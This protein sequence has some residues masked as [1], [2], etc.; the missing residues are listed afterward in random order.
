VRVLLLRLRR[1]IRW[2]FSQQ[3]RSAADRGEDVDAASMPARRP[4][5]LKAAWVPPSLREVDGATR[6]QHQ[7]RPGECATGGTRTSG[8]ALAWSRLMLMTGRT[9]DL[10]ERRRHPRGLE[11]HRTTGRHAGGIYILAAVSSGPVLLRE[12]PADRAAQAQE[13]YAHA[14]P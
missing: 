10:S 4:M 3:D 5:K 11:L 6:H 12:L 9:V 1:A 13:E 8:G 2:E 14:F 7:P